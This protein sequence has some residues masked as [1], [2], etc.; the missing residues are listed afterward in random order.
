[1]SNGYFREIDRG[2]SRYLNPATKWIIIANVVIFLVQY[3]VLVILGL[4]EIFTLLF[5]QIPFFAVQRFQVWRFVTYMFLH[6]GG[7]HLL[8]NML[9][10]FF[11]A[12]RLEDKWGSKGFLK[13]YFVCGIGAAIVHA[14]FTYLTSEP[15]QAMLGASGAVYGIL[16]AYALY[17]PEQKVL[18]YFFIPIKIKYL[19]VIFGLLEFMGTVGVSGDGISHITHLGGLLTAFI[20]LRGWNKI[21]NLFG[22]GGG[23]RGGPRGPRKVVK[24]YYRDADGKIYV[25]FDEE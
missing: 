3:V 19:V 23:F 22:G 12:G 8:F 6:G 1:M 21:S 14:L 16:L 10:L 25:E 18:L 2:L 15:F 9:A 11:F 4:R 20:Y 7:M 13:F 17:W 24:R 5:C